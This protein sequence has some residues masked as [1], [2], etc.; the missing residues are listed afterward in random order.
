[1]HASPLS[2]PTTTCTHTSFPLPRRIQHRFVWNAHCFPRVWWRLLWPVLLRSSHKHH[3]FHVYGRRLGGPPLNPFLLL[4][5]V[6]G[7]WQHE[8]TYQGPILFQ[9]SNQKT[10]KC[11]HHRRSFVE[12]TC[13]SSCSLS[14]LADTSL[15]YTL[16]GAQ[17]QPLARKVG[18]HPPD[19]IWVWISQ[20]PGQHISTA[21][22][23]FGPWFH[24]FRDGPYGVQRT[25]QMQELIHITG[26]GLRARR[27][28]KLF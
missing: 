14:D 15:C 10:N 9:K 23:F 8:S 26:S 12:E 16:N 22:V 1:M 21:W 4:Y 13:T 27:Y 6:L 28:P 2:L 17:L 25:L 19:G 24:S 5:N 18:Y 11:L 20:I 7:I 3:V